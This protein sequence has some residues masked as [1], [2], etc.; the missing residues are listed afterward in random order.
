MPRRLEAVV[1]GCTVELEI[2][3]ALVAGR[4]LARTDDMVILTDD[5]NGHTVHVRYDY[6]LNGWT[7]GG[8]Q[9]QVRR[10]K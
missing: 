5:A 8:R 4:V 9:A 10:T 1:V 7:V 6:A 2:G 3:G